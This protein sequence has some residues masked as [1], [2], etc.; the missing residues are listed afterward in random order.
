MTDIL[1]DKYNIKNKLKLKDKMASYNTGHFSLHNNF[2][3]SDM[4]DFPFFNASEISLTL[5]H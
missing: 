3:I 2:Q 1:R 5:P 4:V